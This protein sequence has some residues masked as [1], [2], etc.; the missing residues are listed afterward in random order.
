[1]KIAQNPKHFL[2]VKAVQ[3]LFAW[4]FSQTN[5]PVGEFAVS[6]VHNLAQIDKQI[7][8]AAPAW[9]VDKINRIDLAILRIAVYELLIEAVT[10]PKVAID[11]AIEIAK[12]F[13]SD[14]SPAFINGALGKLV[15]DHH[16][17]T[18]D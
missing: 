6:V 7:E 10:P 13:G 4:N 12:E 8:Q 1:M 15:T 3:E 2:R 11:E 16:I 5:E 17:K 18:D 9:P 14:S